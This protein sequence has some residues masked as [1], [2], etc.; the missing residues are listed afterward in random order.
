MR[1]AFEGFKTERVWGVCFLNVSSP[2]RAYG[3]PLTSNIFPVHVVRPVFTAYTRRTTRTSDGWALWPRFFSPEK[4]TPR[5]G[6][7]RR[8]R[9]STHGSVSWPYS[10]YFFVVGN[11][12]GAVIDDETVRLSARYVR[13]SSGASHR[14]K[15][16]GR[17]RV[18]S[19]VRNRRA[20]LGEPWCRPV[21]SKTT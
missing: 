10:F 19:L 4:V 21:E 17:F 1:F 5:T 11:D 12:F 6:K 3:R 7:S 13:T 2:N 18:F 16:T 20:D 8:T 15:K 9:R 14:G